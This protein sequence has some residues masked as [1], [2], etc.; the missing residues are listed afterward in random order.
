MDSSLPRPLPGALAAL[1]PIADRAPLILEPAPFAARLAKRRLVAPVEHQNDEIE[2]VIRLARF[3]IQ[4]PDQHG[5]GVWVPEPAR[6]K[7]R[8]GHRVAVAGRAMRKE[9]RVVVGP[10]ALIESGDHFIG[11]GADKDAPP[12]LERRLEQGRQRLVD[13]SPLE[14][15]KTNLR[16]WPAGPTMTKVRSEPV[17]IS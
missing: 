16:H 1:A 13:A 17:A 4:K 2:R 15:V 14:M 8:L 5:R 3:R 12:V 7:D 6:Q 11:G 9:A 10:K